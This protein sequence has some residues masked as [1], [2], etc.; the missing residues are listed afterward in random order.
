VVVVVVVVVPYHPPFLHYPLEEVG[1]GDDDGDVDETDVCVVS[2][3]S[4]GSDVEKGD[5]GKIVP[6]KA[7]CYVHRMV[8]TEYHDLVVYI[9]INHVCV[10]FIRKKYTVTTSFGIEPRTSNPLHSPSPIISSLIYKNTKE[11]RVV[12]I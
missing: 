6:S 2:C 9:F 4:A 5:V 10:Y 1:E 8:P 3:C 11:Q 12:P 7:A